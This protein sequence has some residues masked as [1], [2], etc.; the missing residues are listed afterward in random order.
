LILDEPTDGLDPNQKHEMRQLIARMGEAGKTII[1]STHIL[2][3]VD[4][5]CQRVIIIAKGKLVADAAPA[6]LAEKSSFHNAVTMRFSQNIVEAASS[7]LNS[8]NDFSKVQIVD[9]LPQT[10]RVFPK[11]GQDILQKVSAIA[12]DKNWDIEQIHVEQGRLD[13]VFRRVTL[14]E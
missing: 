11:E 14:G 3:E 5:V 13:D 1:L 6:K 7:D 9:S 8:K 12:K 2:E 10:L 4:A